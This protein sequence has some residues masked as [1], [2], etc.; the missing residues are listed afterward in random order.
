MAVQQH[1]SSRYVAQT[2]RKEKIAPGSV[3]IGAGR[4]KSKKSPGQR[5]GERQ[6]QAGGNRPRKE[7]PLQP[8]QPSVS[9]QRNH[10]SRQQ[11]RHHRLHH[12][13]TVVDRRP[14][15]KRGAQ[16][17][18]Q[19]FCRRDIQRHIRRGSHDYD[20]EKA[21]LPI[22]KAL[23]QKKAQADAHQKNQ[24]AQLIFDYI[25]HSALRV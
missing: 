18:L 7:N 6:Q 5:I 11:H 2:F 25:H 17:Q 24:R 15:P 19:K 23:P 16:P 9:Q 3:Y 4:I 1:Q 20:A 22:G 13:M 21:I 14:Y 10:I 8:S 12:T